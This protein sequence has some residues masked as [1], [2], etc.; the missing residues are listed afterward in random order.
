MS[1]ETLHVKF[2]RG[3]IV[4]EIDGSAATVHAEL[5]ALKKEGYGRL[6]E[7]LAGWTPAPGSVPEPGPSPGSGSPPEPG[8]GSAPEAPLVPIAAS[9]R[10]LRF[11]VNSIWVP[12]QGSDYAVDLNGDGR[13]DNQFGNVMGALVGTLNTDFQGSV[14][15]AV[16][17]FASPLLLRFDTEQADLT[18]DQR[19]DMTILSGTVLD[20]GQRIFQVDT[21]RPS[22]TLRCRLRSGRAESQAPLRGGAVVTLPV[23]LDLFWELPVILP[24]RAAQMSFTLAG[25]GLSLDAGLISGAVSASDFQSHFFPPLAKHLSAYVAANPD[26][27]TSTQ[28]LQL[29]DTGGCT[30]PDGTQAKAM[31]GVIDVCEL[32]THPIMQ[33]LLRPDV[34]LFDDSGRYSPQATATKKDSLSVGLGFSAIAA[35]F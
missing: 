5:L 4:V 34:Q 32:L 31:D 21:S 7:F 33:A 2:Q 20:A 27:S 19:I 25:D 24:M 35:T 12:W 29:F 26:S 22:V 3:E 23:T 14:D 18:V 30:N 13:V 9:A 10:T 15:K 16:A 6:L 28:I 17:A 1:H 11:V 8:F